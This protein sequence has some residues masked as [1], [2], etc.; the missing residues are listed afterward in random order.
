MSGKPE[1]KIDIAALVNDAVAKMRHWEEQRSAVAQK[2]LT[3]PEILT[4]PDDDLSD[5]ILR[6]IQKLKWGQRERDDPLLSLPPVLRTV[7]TTLTLD[8]EI[9]NGGFHQFFW[10]TEGQ[11]DDA[12]EQD[13][14]S[15]GASEFRELFAE[16]RQRCQGRQPK[17]GWFRNLWA[18]ADFARGYDAH[19]FDDLESR[20]F[21]VKPELP[22]L[23]ANFLRQNADSVIN[24]LSALGSP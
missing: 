14:R 20:Y 1:Q 21:N 18:W 11:M 9:K 2:E 16:A 12:T 7:H 6:K 5:R 17:R 3:R 19:Q 10:N 24:E 15:I 8:G 23:L 13:L 22:S 4:L